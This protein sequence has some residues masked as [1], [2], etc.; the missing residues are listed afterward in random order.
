MDMIVY[1]TEKVLEHKKGNIKDDDYSPYGEYVWKLERGFPK[2]V[3]PGD[4]IYFA[5][6]KA[7]QGYFK[8]E[9]VEYPDIIFNCN[10]WRD[11]KPIPQKPF[12]GFKYKRD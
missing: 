12:Q 8:I 6:N 5:I 4:K 9:E 2:N 10:S 7:I 11:I 3:E 1:T